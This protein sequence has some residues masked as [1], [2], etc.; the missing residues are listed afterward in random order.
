[1]D[2]DSLYADNDAKCGD[3]QN[4]SDVGS[5]MGHLV[6]YGNGMYLAVQGDGTLF[7]AGEYEPSV[8]AMA[9]EF[10]GH[11]VT[12]SYVQG[13]YWDDWKPWTDLLAVYV[14]V[15]LDYGFFVGLKKNGRTVA[16]GYNG[17]GQC[18]D[19]NSWYGI[20]SVEFFLHNAVGLTYTG[21]LLC[22]GKLK[23]NDIWLAQK[24]VKKIC[25]GGNRISIL[26]ETG[27]VSILEFNDES[28]FVGE[29]NNS[30]EEIVDIFSH[31]NRTYA[32]HRDGR[33]FIIGESGVDESVITACAGVQKIISESSYTVALTSQKGGSLI[34]A[35]EIPAYFEKAKEWKNIRDIVCWN[36]VLIGI[37]FKEDIY[38]TNHEDEFLTKTIPV[39]KRE[40]GD[41]VRA[42]E[43]SLHLEKDMILSICECGSLL[44]A[45]TTAGRLLFSGDP[46]NLFERK[47]LRSGIT[48]YSKDQYLTICAQAEAAAKEEADR[49]DRE[50]QMAE[51]RQKRVC[52]HCGG[53]FAG[54]LVKTCQECG[55]RKDY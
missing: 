36:D 25:S 8:A 22:S 48:T 43:L 49:M 47:F 23:N 27:T 55:K 32:I 24:G 17:E 52:Q 13:Y 39:W 31:G 1:M 44:I 15:G 19:I 26:K 7:V 35:G 9:R 40:W 45:V 38:I 34:F 18:N 3:G 6:A 51:Y 29:I 42:W 16:A 4:L 30:L 2:Q 37:S 21:K 33:V 14:M 41:A 54:L 28:V 20:K 50:R 10:S 5:R 12:M 11:R 53:K 46:T